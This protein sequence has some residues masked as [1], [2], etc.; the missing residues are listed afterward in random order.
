MKIPVIYADRKSGVVRAEELQD[1]LETLKIVS[2]KRSGGWVK[3]GIDPVRGEGGRKYRG[4]ERRGN[5][6]FY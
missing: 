4:P 5:V 1:L 6:Q 2:F 3:V